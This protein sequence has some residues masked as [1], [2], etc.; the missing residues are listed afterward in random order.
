MDTIAYFTKKHCRSL[1]N[2]ARLLLLIA[3]AAVAFTGI[4]G[5]AGIAAGMVLVLMTLL[6]AFHMAGQP[7]GCSLLQI[8]FAILS[9]VSFFAGLGLS[10]MGFLALR[11]SP[12]EEDIHT[13]AA[14]VGIPLD[15][16][17]HIP[18][19]PLGI[20]GMLLFFLSFV[21][22]CAVM[23]LSTVKSCLSNVI[24]RHGA[25][26]FTACSILTAI[27][28]AAGA[29]FFIL[30]CGGWSAVIADRQNTSLL[31]EIV[32]FALVLLITGCSA[33]AFLKPTYAF[34]VFE[35]KM[36][37]VEMNA[38]G[39]MYVP[40]QED[41]DGEEVQP[42]P[43]PVPKYTASDKT[44]RKPPIKSYAE[45]ETVYPIDGSHNESCIN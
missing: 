40:I 19:M 8:P 42:L 41:T 2:I 26:V 15:R 21:S 33:N 36:M 45:Q 34:K 29:V 24:S 4:P 1:F 6:C 5:A 44:G 23:Y 25:R 12:V 28:V 30:R 20:V 35:D 32:L 3:M 9:F 11:Y 27:A 22:F 39:T 38:D 16:I 13:A 14:S 31:A 10:I 18:G 7:L 43:V 17:V 37:K